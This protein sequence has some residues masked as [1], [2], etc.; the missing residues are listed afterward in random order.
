MSN[1]LIPAEECLDYRSDT[2]CAGPVVYRLSPNG[3]GMRIPRCERHEDEVEE[4]R[5]E[6]AERYPDSPFAPSWFDPAY[7]GE[8][9]DEDY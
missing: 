9:W 6:I 4:R 2:K 3:T 1:Q 7:A 8:R 5:A